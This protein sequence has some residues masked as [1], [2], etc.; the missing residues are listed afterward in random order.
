MA[1]GRSVVR[2]TGW[3][4]ATCG[5]PLAA[6]KRPA[7]DSLTE[8]PPAS[9]PPSQRCSVAYRPLPF[10]REWGRGI[11]LHAFG[12]LE[13]NVPPVRQALAPV[14]ALRH[15]APLNHS[16]CGSNQRTAESPFTLPSRIPSTAS[17]FPFIPGFG[18]PQC[19]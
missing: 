9:H 19:S 14:V 16:S 13:L 6:G 11:I 4:T 18:K 12:F 8:R 2:C 5:A 3:R 17:P 1:K 15:T 7:R 10:A